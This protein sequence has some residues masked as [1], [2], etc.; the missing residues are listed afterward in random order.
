MKSRFFLASALLLAGCQIN[1]TTKTVDAPTNTPPKEVPAAPVTPSTPPAVVTPQPQAVVVAPVKLPTPQEQENLWQRISMQLTAEVPDNKSVNY[2]RNWYLRH[3][4]HLQT[5]AN[6]AQPFLFLITEEI[7]KRNMP[8]ELALLPV[9]E[10]SFD[11]FAYS[12]GRA[13]GLWQITPPTGRTFGLKQDWWYDGRRDVVEST[14]A[15]LD[16]L[17]YL[18]RKFDGNWLHALAAYNTGEGRV[19]RA[20]RNNKAAGKPTDFWHLDLPKE[21]S[22]YVPKLLAVADVIKN[23]QKYGL[24]LPEIAN[25]PA[26]QLVKPGTQMDL[27]MAAQFAGISL[28]EMQSL[29]PGYNHWATAPDGPSHLLLPVGHVDNFNTAFAKNGHRGM[30]VIRYK[31]QSG[32]TLSVLA[33]KYKT[34]TK[35]IQRANDMSNTN[36]RVGRHIL[37]PVA[38]KDGDTIAMRLEGKTQRSHGGGYR[39]DYIVKGGDS[40]WSI[41]RSEKVSI[42]ELT[43]WNGLSKKSTLRVG[44]KLTLWK[45][46]ASG[47]IIR[48]VYYKVRSGD[49]L[50]A[51]AQRYKVKVSD[52]V[53]WNKISG[54]KYLKPGQQLKLY[55]DVTK[56][57][58]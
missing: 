48:T 10:S 57:S 51:I 30:K 36:I 33:R 5:V 32:D 24:E 19:F 49:N 21:T 41:A 17:Q 23:Q 43:K 40:L 53:K 3:P 31:V 1:N 13:A 42:D 45:D 35:Q 58:V 8:L 2:Y 11:Q 34:T 4:G 25:K 44:Q 9:V 14:R 27:A 6:R 28:D 20:I 37:I 56:V 55:V 16:L 22:G 54:K 47:G 26:V 7:E 18:N 50:S 39:T 15:A 38:M 12:H 29:N 52:V 46:N